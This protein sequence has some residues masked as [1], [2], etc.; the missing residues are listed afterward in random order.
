MGMKELRR[1][2]NAPTPQQFRRTER[3][4]THCV[5]P[6]TCETTG[7]SCNAEFACASRSA[8]A[9]DT[10][11]MR[12][13]HG[14]AL[15]VFLHIGSVADAH[16]VRTGIVMRHDIGLPVLLLARIDR[17]PAQVALRGQISARLAPKLRLRGNRL[18]LHCGGREDRRHQS[19][20][21]DCQRHPH[22]CA[23]PNPN[24]QVLTTPSSDGLRFRKL[25]QPPSYPLSNVRTPCRANFGKSFAPT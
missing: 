2:Q 25:R 18:C 14:A 11:H 23:H 24:S 13:D 17:H 22:H 9:P 1:K 3:H 5:L 21:E 10:A 19:R 4:F 6:A 20:P 15:P 12:H 7:R 16:R 8:A